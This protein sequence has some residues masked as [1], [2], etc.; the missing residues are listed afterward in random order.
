MT[1]SHRLAPAFIPQTPYTIH[2]VWETPD[3]KTMP[4][5]CPQPCIKEFDHFWRLI[6]F[7]NGSGSEKGKYVSIFLLHPQIKFAHE[8]SYIIKTIGPKSASCEGNWVFSPVVNNRGAE[9]FIPLNEIDDYLNDGKLKFDI[10]IKFEPPQPLRKL[11]CRDSVGVVGLTNLG[12][13]CYLN[14]M[15]Q[16]LFH[17]PAFRRAVYNMPTDGTEDVKKSIAYSLQ[18]LFTLMQMSPLTPSTQE[19]TTSFGWGVTDQFSQHDVQEFLRVLVDNLEK[20][21]KKTENKDAFA[22]IFRGKTLN[23]LSV[24]E[25]DYKDEHKEEFYDI[26]LVVRNNKDLMEAIRE[27]THSETIDEYKVENK[28]VS[29]AI[30]S[31]KFWE[32][33]NVL[34]FLLQ[35]FEYS[36]AGS[37]MVKVND[38]FEFPQEL[39]MKE[40]MDPESPDK[41]T[42]YDLFG[43]LIHMGVAQAGHYEALMKIGDEWML[44]N[45]DEVT[46]VGADAIEQ[47]FGGQNTFSSAYFVTYVRRSKPEIMKEVTDDEIPAHL[48]KYFAEFIKQNTWKTPEVNL[49]IHG[50]NILAADLAGEVPEFPIVSVPL[51]GY[52]VKDCL[53]SIA[54]ALNVKPPIQLFTMD[55]NGLPESPIALSQNISDQFEKTQKLYA[56]TS[57]DKGSI[58][59]VVGFYNPS[60][61]KAISYLFTSIVESGTLVNSFIDKV[62][63]TAKSKNLVA[64]KVHGTAAAK[65]ALDSQINRGGLIIFQYAEKKSA[66]KALTSP[67]FQVGNTYRSIDVVPELRDSNVDAFLAGLDDPLTLT[68]SNVTDKAQTFKLI[69]SAK[70]H[71]SLLIK[72][73]RSILKTTNDKA[74]LL[75]RSEKGSPSEEPINTNTAANVRQLVP[76]TE[77]FFIIHNGISQSEIEQKVFFRPEVVL[78]NGSKNPVLLMPKDF[79]VDTVLQRL[80]RINLI[81]NKKKWRMLMLEGSRIVKVCQNDTKLESFLTKKF[82][83]ETIPD[84]QVPPAKTVRVTLSTL[85]SNPRNNTTGTPFIFTLKEGEKFTETKQRLLEQSGADK[86]K[87]QFGY[88]NDMSNKHKAPKDDD[89]LFEKIESNGMLYIFVPGVVKTKRCHQ[90]GDGFQIYN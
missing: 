19:L 26:E 47:T 22:N 44:F 75:F 89:E 55:I 6:V 40:F 60:Q 33:P 46:K 50:D 23:K 71:I 49:E 58:P 84:D 1:F 9:K 36:F 30:K 48:H 76:G 7:K 85:P 78:S 51:K 3:F 14:S 25:F 67:Q 59:V 21:L 28:G 82:R 29:K 52:K 72:S 32:L 80:Q 18:R 4:E 73:I 66:P 69:I 88:S 24:E 8:V 20:K 53:N 5:S 17:T 2:N 68:L 12:A 37:G 81:E 41:D 56:T 83:I 74:V 39:D 13:T 79:T 38:R 15:L 61:V 10:A 42:V 65:I 45:D 62:S 16:N 64:F 35:R 63:E 54:A 86:E 57:K 11:S 90:S 31:A 43:V 87:A 77:A 27:Y 70:A 34:H